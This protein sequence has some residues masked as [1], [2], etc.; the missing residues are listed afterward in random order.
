MNRTWI[1]FAFSSLVFLSCGAKEVP[2]QKTVESAPPIEEPD[3]VD[4]PEDDRPPKEEIELGLEGSGSGNISV[5]V[6]NDEP[7]EESE[8]AT[9]PSEDGLDWSC[10]TRQDCRG[11][12]LPKKKTGG[13]R[14][15][16]SRCVFVPGSKGMKIPEEELKELNK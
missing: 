2:A 9:E 12:G 8:P 5:D 13:W 16:K 1:V 4:E 7:D 11:R 14:C 3:E 10:K 15:Q 6:T